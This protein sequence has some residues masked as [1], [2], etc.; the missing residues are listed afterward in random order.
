MK[1]LFKLLRR[2]LLVV[3]LL[4][5]VLYFARN[6]VARHAVMLAV[7]KLSGFSLEI[8]SVDV[9][10]GEETLEVRDMRISN[11]PEFHGGTFA[12]VPWLRVRYDTLSLIRRAPHIREL[13]VH[14]T[15]LVLV[16]NESGRTNAKVLQD[17]ITSLGRD[18]GRSTGP[19]TSRVPAKV[20]KTPYR[21]D[22]LKLRLGTVT[23][24][25]F[26]SRDRF[27]ETKYVLNLNATYRNITE[28]TS[29]TRLV[30]DTVFAQLG[31]VAG[32]MI[33]GVGEAVRGA[34]GALQ[35][36]ARGIWGIFRKKQQ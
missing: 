18:T 28:A 10:P 7:T 31:D 14:V 19:G 30:M 17:R 21:V 1:F 9:R 2:L 8:G 26:A 25:T 12:V 6:V 13:E 32:D 27:T 22:V 24:R 16:K 15:E 35:K 11:P 33:R 34:A 5:V 36:T 20:S 29:L 3:I 23:K 4:A